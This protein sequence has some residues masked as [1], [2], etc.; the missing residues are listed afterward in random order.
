MALE[1]HRIAA[2]RCTVA[3]LFTIIFRRKKSIFYPLPIKLLLYM[4]YGI[5]PAFSQYY[6][7]VQ[8]RRAPLYHRRKMLARNAN[9][10]GN[11]RRSRNYYRFS[12]K[13]QLV[14][15]LILFFVSLSFVLLSCSCRVNV[16]GDNSV[17]CWRLIIWR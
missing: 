1:R 2:Q 7:I 6:G 3:E 14:L 13:Y 17:Q 15:R 9:G 16:L 10:P 12:G 4:R 8:I 11:Q 5:R